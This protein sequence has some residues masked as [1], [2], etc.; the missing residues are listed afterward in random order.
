[1]K[2]RKKD[3]QATRKEHPASSQEHPGPSQEHPG[4]EGPPPGRLQIAQIRAETAPRRGR[5]PTPRCPQRGQQGQRQ[6]QWKGGRSYAG[7]SAS[8][9]EGPQ[10]VL[11]GHGHVQGAQNG[12]HAVRG[13]QPQPHLAKLGHSSQG[14]LRR[15]I[16]QVGGQHS[17][18][19]LWTPTATYAG[20]TPRRESRRLRHRHHPKSLGRVRARLRRRRR[21]GKE[22]EQNQRQG[23]KNG[24]E[25]MIWMMH[26]RGTRARSRRMGD[27]IREGDGDA[28]A[29]TD[30]HLRRGP[31]RRARARLSVATWIARAPGIHKRGGEKRFAR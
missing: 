11:Q 7:D 15:G 14:T 5:A 28:D 2:A 21:A 30:A 3:W 27:D 18:A 12:G 13:A 26:R 29:D 31:I 17:G 20:R 22:E 25:S 9:T 16:R 6:S 23:N 4:S 24:Q 8:K 19:Q 10:Q 1:M